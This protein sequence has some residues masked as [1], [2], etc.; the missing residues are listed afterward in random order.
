MR[1]LARVRA[2]HSV[3]R[4]RRCLH[5]R[6]LNPLT[7]GSSILHSICSSGSPVYHTT[8]QGPI[9]YRD[10][11]SP[12][13]KHLSSTA[14]HLRLPSVLHQSQAEALARSA[15]EAG[16]LHTYGPTPVPRGQA[17]SIYAHLS[18]DPAHPGSLEW[19][20]VLRWTSPR[21]TQRQY[22]KKTC[23]PEFVVSAPKPAPGNTRPIWP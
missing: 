22:P 12:Y 1:R 9:D 2:S 8:S 6:R 5:L 16:G 18:L 14:L 11:R 7:K 17:V 19:P 4:I 13:R 20:A 15:N 23:E 21:H 3:H 10:G